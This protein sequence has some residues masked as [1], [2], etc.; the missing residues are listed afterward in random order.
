MIGEHRVW[1]GGVKGNSELSA[2]SAPGVYVN[3]YATSGRVARCIYK[4]KVAV[5]ARKDDENDAHQNEQ[6]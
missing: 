4:R 6:I 5:L 3:R 2:E 1:N